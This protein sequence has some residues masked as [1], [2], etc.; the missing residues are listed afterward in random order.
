M[1]SG[2]VVELVAVHRHEQG[3]DRREHSERE[4]SEGGCDPGGE[5]MFVP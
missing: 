1:S 5:H 3:A 4:P 2:A